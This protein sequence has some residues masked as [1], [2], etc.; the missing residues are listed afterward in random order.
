M[1]QNA[2]E[3]RQHLAHVQRLTQR[4]NQH[5]QRLRALRHG[6]DV[7]LPDAVEVVA[8]EQTAIGRNSYDRFAG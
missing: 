5:G 3:V 6:A 7:L 4:R 8:A 2:V 1:K